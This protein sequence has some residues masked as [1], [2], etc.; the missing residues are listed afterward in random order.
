MPFRRRRRFRRRRFRRRRGGVARL[1]RTAYF[2]LRSIR[3]R[4]EN[5]VIVN[6]FDS[7]VSQDSPTVNAITNVAQGD[8]VGQRSGYSMTI[9]SIRFNAVAK[10]GATNPATVRV[11]VFVDKQHLSDTDP[12]AASIL[13]AVDPLSSLNPTHYGHFRIL[14]DKVIPLSDQKD[15]VYIK[16]VIRLNHNVRFNGA[17]GGDSQRGTIYVLA[18]SDIAALNDP[19]TLKWNIQT[20]FT[21]N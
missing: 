12:A 19:P 15:I 9:R 13:A 7:I 21:D 2:G 14:Y 17:N 5:K 6:T 8:D 4:M 16:R 1:A 10:L 18:L 11:M 20:L 3:R